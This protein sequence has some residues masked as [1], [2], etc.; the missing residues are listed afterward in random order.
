[1]SQNPN[2]VLCT[3][4][5]TC[6]EGSLF[7]YAATPI[8]RDIVASH[9][10]DLGTPF[11]FDNN[12]FRL[13][14]DPG[15]SSKIRVIRSLRDR[16]S[17]AE[18]A[19]I[20]VSSEKGA[21]LLA[22]ATL[23]TFGEKLDT[24]WF[25]DAIRANG[26]TTFF[27]PI[28]FFAK[29]E[30]GPRVFAHECLIRLFADRAYNGGEIIDAAIA[31]GSVHLFDSYARRLNIRSAGAQVRQGTKVFVN[32]MPSSI[33]DPVF[34]M[35]STLDE[36]SRTDIRPSDFVFEVVESDQIRDV[37]HLGKICDYYRKGGFG[38]AMDDV[39]TGSNSLQTVC[40]L[41]PDFIKLDKSLILKID[42]PMYRTVVEKLAEFAYKYDVKVIAE[43]VETAE[44][45]D[46]LLEIGISYMQG[47]YFGRPSAMM[48]TGDSDL[49]RLSEHLGKTAVKS[50]ET[51][52]ITIET[53]LSCV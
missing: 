28:V 51:R 14:F 6:P 33:Y 39:G 16:L 40:D 52:R 49:T 20:R 41:K 21:A 22:A 36:M 8:L 27:Q 18:R 53:P 23:D 17:D 31:R 43:C 4:K 13:A 46:Q 30:I 5:H 26:Y 34:C 12:L 48:A 7:L 44:A 35:A 50:T 2:C 24:E 45:M 47:Y 19:D 29:P 11:L 38:F 9:L 25:E 42:Q 15:G 32:F 10:K 3:L 1:M 37:K